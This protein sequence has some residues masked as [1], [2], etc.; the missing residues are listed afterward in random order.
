MLGRGLAWVVRAGRKGKGW[1]KTLRVGREGEGWR[2]EGG[3]R[4]LEL[5]SE[6]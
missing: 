2:G 6:R 4:G 5:R 1:R 3:V